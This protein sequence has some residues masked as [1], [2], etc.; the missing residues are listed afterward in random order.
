MDNAQR[1]C[2]KNRDIKKLQAK[3]VKKL[4]AEKVKKLQAMLAKINHRAEKWTR[5]KS[6][7]FARK[8]S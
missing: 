8:A 2:T 6:Q 3:K 1:W 7:L 4:Q 5:I